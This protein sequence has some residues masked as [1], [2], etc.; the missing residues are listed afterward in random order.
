VP[1]AKG[2]EFTRWSHQ[3]QDNLYAA[4]L[5][6]Y[7]LKFVLRLGRLTYGWGT[8]WTKFNP[9]DFTDGI[10]RQKVYEIK[11]QLLEK[12]VIKPRYGG[13]GIERRGEKWKVEWLAEGYPKEVPRWSKVS[14]SDSEVGEKLSPTSDSLSPTS[15]NNLSPTSDKVVTHQVQSCHPPVTNT[16]SNHLKS[17]GNSDAKDKKDNKDKIYSEEFEKFWEIYPRKIEK[18]NAYRFW[19][20]HFEKHNRFSLEEVIQTLNYYV[21]REWKQNLADKKMNFI[22]LCATWLNRRPWEDEGSRL[23]D[24]IETK[25]EEYWINVYEKEVKRAEERFEGARLDEELSN[26][27]RQLNKKLKEIK[28][29]KA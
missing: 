27:E 1:R 20:S 23:A 8:N 26:L 25:G 14:R 18:A 28:N 6:V 11:K 13:I 10:P 9:H 12:K 16:P 4:K 17:A 24:G 5:T 29:G 15:D 7:E 21:A 2:K 22:P 3:L 19:K